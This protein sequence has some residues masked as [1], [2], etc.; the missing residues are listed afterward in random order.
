MMQVTRRFTH[1]MV[2]LLAASLPAWAG[3]VDL[4]PPPPEA[5]ASPT[6]P[7]SLRDATFPQAFVA[8]LS[9][10]GQQGMAVDIGVE[11]APP[12]TL[13]LEAGTLGQAMGKL[14]EAFGGQWTVQDGMVL[15]RRGEV[16]GLLT[17]PRPGRGGAGAAQATRA[18]A[19]PGTPGTTSLV[20]DAAALEDVYARLSTWPQLD[21][22][23]FPAHSD[24][25]GLI[26]SPCLR[27]L[28]I[29]ARLQD[30]PTHL[31]VRA[32]EALVGG[33]SRFLAGI[34]ATEPSAALLLR[35]AQEAGIP[36]E[37]ELALAAGDC[38]KV[39]WTHPARAV[40]TIEAMQALTPEETVLVEEGGRVDVEVARLSVL[41]CR[42]L[43]AEIER[44]RKQEQEAR[45]PGH[46]YHA[47][48]WN[49]TESW[50]VSVTVDG[51]PRRLQA[52]IVYLADTPQPL[53]VAF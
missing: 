21:A 37:E 11:Q 45:T 5:I 20:A 52:G 4:E 23:G 41:G 13:T 12:I 22:S 1:A 14:V 9:A 31:V 40:L 34:H 39:L 51:F 10:G 8:V 36:G 25:Y 38:T 3:L 32:I 26:C 49:I 50:R 35:A 43:L 6:Q 7:I 19:V 28:P 44:L 27:G 24:A 16:W 48:N 33:R 15:L 17:G 46:V 2:A 18:L 30:Q 42:A 53:E 47:P 29:T